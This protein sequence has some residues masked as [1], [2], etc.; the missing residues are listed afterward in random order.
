LTYVED[1]P[2]QFDGVRAKLDRADQHL[3]TLQHAFDLW[4]GGETYEIVDVI[5][6]DTGEDILTFRWVTAQPYVEWGLLVGDCVHN[7]RS[8][9]DHLVYALAVN[10]SGV[11]PPPNARRLQ[12]PIADQKNAFAAERNRKLKGLPEHLVSKIE[13]CQPYHRFGPNP[14]TIIREVSNMDKHRVVPVA[15]STLEAIHA[16]AVPERDTRAIGI[17][18]YGLGPLLA[19]TPLV[20]FR[21]EVTGP[22]P[23]VRV[24]HDLSYALTLNEGT[25]LSSLRLLDVLASAQPFIDEALIR[26]LG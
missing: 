25:V 20:K 13:G 15:V 11:D 9:L 24:D 14:L 26:R 7:L 1:M 4:V 16:S 5:D 10:S 2:A 17:E 19:D 23:S 8:A 21:F 12:F 18:D 6:Y 3:R 22:R